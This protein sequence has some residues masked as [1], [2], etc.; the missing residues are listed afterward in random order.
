MR[1]V[2]PAVPTS[3]A[4]CRPPP[5]PA[6]SEKPPAVAH[7]Q[8]PSQMGAEPGHMTTGPSGPGQEQCVQ[9]LQVIQRSGGLTE[10]SQCGVTLASPLL[11]GPSGSPHRPADRSLVGKG[12]IQAKLRRG[13]ARRRKSDGEVGRPP[14][15]PP[16]GESPIRFP[17]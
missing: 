15:P 9:G 3:P 5:S 14:G 17:V 7:S 4:F 13:E 16:T 2:G 6:C 12:S 11:A 10:D 8:G 1:S